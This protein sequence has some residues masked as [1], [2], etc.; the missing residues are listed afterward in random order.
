MTAQ[1]KSA[2]SMRSAAESSASSSGRPSRASV[3]TRRSSLPMG[4]STSWDTASTPCM[5]E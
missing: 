2:L 3:T 5:S 1:A 4:S